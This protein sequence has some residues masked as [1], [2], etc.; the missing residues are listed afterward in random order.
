MT[1]KQAF[2]TRSLNYL[3]KSLRS[4]VDMQYD[5]CLYKCSEK[6]TAGMQVCK[7]ECVTNVLVPYRFK[8]H[9]AKDE[10]DNL[11]RK[12]LAQKFPNISQDD[13][14]DCTHQLYKDR[15]KIIGDQFV[16]IYEELFT[17]MH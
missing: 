11:Y 6:S 14:I 12:C 17:E 3:D 7:N 1:E 2:N 9:A 13:Y 4:L 16:N 10:E 5:F 8:T 15:I